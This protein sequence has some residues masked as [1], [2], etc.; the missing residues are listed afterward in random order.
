MEKDYKVAWKHAVNQNDWSNFL[1]ETF[2]DVSRQYAYQLL[3]NKLTNSQNAKTFAEVGFGQGFDFDNCFRLLHQENKIVYS[4]HE[5]TEQFVNFAKN[6]WPGFEFVLDEFLYDGDS[7]Y[8]IVYTRHVI[9]HQPPDKCYIA[10]ERVL[11]RTN[12]FCIVAWFHAPDVESFQWMSWAGIGA[13]G[14]QVNILSK[15]KVLNI[16]QKNGFSLE[17]VNIGQSVLYILSRIAF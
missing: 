4:G 12:E 3:S 9:E 14:A 1:S 16:I 5:V 2:Q 8:D 11:Q 17:V 10:F 15:E 7:S 6:K 13:L